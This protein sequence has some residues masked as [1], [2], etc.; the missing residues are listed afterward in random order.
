LDVVE[1]TERLLSAVFAPATGR[2]AEI[3]R[4]IQ[5]RTVLQLA[6]AARAPATSPGAA[7][8]IEQALAELAAKLK[9]TPGTDPQERAHRLHLAVLLSDKDEL[10]RALS[11]PKWRVE[12]PPGMPIGADG[13]LL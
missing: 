5:T 6:V 1:V 11:N 3:A 4:R 13:D 9:A 2:Y 10:R 12:V 7:S 8:Q